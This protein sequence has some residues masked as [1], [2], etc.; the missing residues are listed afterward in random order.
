MTNSIWT[1]ALAAAAML[2]AAQ[3]SAPDRADAREAPRTITVAGHGE[4][5]ATPDVAR[6]ALGVEADGE[7]AEAALGAASER[8]AE[9]L[10]ALDAAGIT[11]SD[12]QTVSLGLY[13]IYA[14]DE[15]N[16][17][18]ET[19]DGYRAQSMLSVK[20]ADIG[21]VGA[22]I[23]T[24]AGAGAN[25]IDAISFELSEPDGP[26]AEARRGAV[27]DAIAR[28]QLYAGA[29]GVGLGPILS[30]SES[31]TGQPGPNPL[32]ARAAEMAAAVPIEQGSITVGADVLVV[33]GIADQP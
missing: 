15:S 12:R 4:V 3:L 6:V 26:T 27:A 14:A 24:L 5:S 32:Y 28:A 8:L 13:P 21:S 33:F 30:I 11:P 19:V 25:R 18:P 7:T 2:V 17:R 1:G 9:I 23:D 20:S 10:A 16:R 22:L 29:A 31:G